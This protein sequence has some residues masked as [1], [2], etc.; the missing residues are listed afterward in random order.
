MSAAARLI[1]GRARR[2]W[3]ASLVIGVVTAVA[4][5]AAVLGAGLLVASDK[6]FEQAFT[7]QRGAHLTIQ[8]DGRRVTAQ[9]LTATAA[10][11]GVTATA[12]PFATV[13]LIPH[14][15]AGTGW[16]TGHE[17]SS[18]R[19][20]GRA[21]HDT[22]VDKVALVDGSWV[23][24]PGQIVVAADPP[25][26]PTGSTLEFPDLPGNPHLTIVG[27]ARSAGRS[28]DAWV[29]P[30]QIR[31][32]TAPGAG[33]EYQ[34]LYRLAAGTAVQVDAGRVAVT[35]AVPAG[36][37]TGLQSWLTVRQ[38]AVRDV[39]LFVPFLTAFGVLGLLLAVMIVANVV[40]GT[41][42][43]GRRRI[44]VLK[45]V[46]ATPVQVVGAYVGRAVIPA[47]AGVAVGLIGGNA[48]AVPILA[49]T[50][51][52]YGSAPGTLPWWVTAGVGVALLG[53][54]AV[55]ALL[56]A[57][58]AARLRT[59]EALTIGQGSSRP[60]AA[61]RRWGLRLPVPL[62]VGLGLLQPL[63]RPSRTAA[64]LTAVVFG[65]A[66]V[67]FAVGLAVSLTEVGKARSHHTDVVVTSI[68]DPDAGAV[69][70]P[71]EIA[72]AIAAR[73]GT[74]SYF[75]VQAMEVGLAGHA[76]PVWLS[77][78]T[79]D[80]TG[81]Y[82]LI[83]GRW[84]TQPGEVVVPATLL[85][86]ANARIGDT[87]ILNQHGADIRV[88]IVGE[89]FDPT[90]DGM[91]A[92]TD[93][94]TITLPAAPQRYQVTVRPG[95]DLD[96]YL[97]DLDAAVQPLG[98]AALPDPARTSDTITTLGALTGLLTTILAAVA[99]LG[100]S[101]IVLLDV[102]E[103]F[104]E[105]GIC[106]AVGM[107]PQQTTAM[108]IASVAVPGLIGGAVGAVLGS[109]VRHLVMPAMQAGIGS[110]FPAT[111]TSGLHPGI[112]VLLGVA[113]LL[114]AVAGALPPALWAARQPAVIALRSE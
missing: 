37:V 22:A 29:W 75:G 109:V 10:V 74:G 72:A 57:L 18:I 20:A 76:G 70:S 46:G 73:P 47:A 71:A 89:V 79:G 80:A 99:A 35:A 63:S 67:T 28:A 23:T 84:F 16:F 40:A 58:R 36:A 62:P 106:K 111:V 7:A 34:M 38:A 59:I 27:T 19:V 83:A 41:V 39:A 104:R 25:P 2:R 5:V 6:P 43:A 64:M 55:V 93:A 3:P 90:R 69:P 61:V 56:A 91:T 12:G 101:N 1:R 100:V 66:T 49:E 97:A 82:Q 68:D 52:A 92:L 96:T 98:A 45:A 87:I 108:V 105:I 44:G 85:D 14:G 77:G 86:A 4:A 65:A 107:S 48:A 33:T 50:T 24:G 51:A 78:F 112:V 42:S 110:R 30:D 8:A 15:G 95:T 21:E 32:L 102:R 53:T 103:R 114:I 11:G 81:S 13:T 54:V 9:Q 94:E 113:G 17:M 31:A 88:R 26:P 60:A